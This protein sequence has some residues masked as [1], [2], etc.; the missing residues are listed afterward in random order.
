MCINSVKNDG[1][2]KIL[3]DTQQQHTQTPFYALTVE[4]LTVPLVQTAN[5]LCELK[6]KLNSPKNDTFPTFT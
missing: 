4:Y 2:L 1:N 3:I 6:I 5:N